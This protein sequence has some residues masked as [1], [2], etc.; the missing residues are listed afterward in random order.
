[1]TLKLGLLV[2]DFRLLLFKCKSASLTS[3]QLTVFIKDFY[4]FHQT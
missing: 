4:V 1:M 2:L 3:L